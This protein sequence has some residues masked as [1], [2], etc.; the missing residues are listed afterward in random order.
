MEAVIPVRQIPRTTSGK[1]QHFK[2]ANRYNDGEF[3]DLLSELQQVG[4]FHFPNDPIEQLALLETIWK[5]ISELNLGTQ[6][7]GF[8]PAGS[9]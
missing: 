3:N 2:L 5:E 6:S 4:D 8:I 1:V 7:D 9:D